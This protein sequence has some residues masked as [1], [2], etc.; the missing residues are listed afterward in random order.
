MIERVSVHR[1]ASWRA[2]SRRAMLRTVATTSASA[3]GGCTA[4]FH[5]WSRSRATQGRCGCAGDALLDL[6][7]C[8]C[9]GLHGDAADDAAP[10]RRR[11]GRGLS[12][13]RLRA[14]PQKQPQRR[15]GKRDL[16]RVVIDRDGVEPA[17]DVLG[18]R[19]HDVA[20]VAAYIN[21]GADLAGAIWNGAARMPNRM[22]SPPPVSAACSATNHGPLRG[23]Q[24]CQHHRGAD[25]RRG[26]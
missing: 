14:E 25:R 1:D 13:L 16:V 9:V 18:R 22:C 23:L 7:A 8:G 6:R 2:I 12:N 26:R 3:R 17:G 10:V 21:A 5:A 15:I 20:A 11:P 4:R 19:R 24:S